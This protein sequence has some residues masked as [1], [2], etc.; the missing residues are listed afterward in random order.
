M[1]ADLLRPLVVPVVGIAVRVIGDDLGEGGG[2]AG[3]VESRQVHG[4]EVDMAV[5]FVMVIRRRD[6]FLRFLLR[7]PPGAT[8]EGIGGVQA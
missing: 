1:P 4:V 6:L 3:V 7:N 2:L 5:M 8:P